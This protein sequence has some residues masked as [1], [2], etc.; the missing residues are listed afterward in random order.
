MGDSLSYLDNLLITS[1]GFF[2]VCQSERS[3]G[4]RQAFPLC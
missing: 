2:R 4:Q 1:N 3:A